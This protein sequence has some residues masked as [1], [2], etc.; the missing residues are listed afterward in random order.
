M[1]PGKR[2]PGEGRL[3]QSVYYAY[4]AMSAV[5]RLLPERVAYPAAQALGSLAAKRSKKRD[6]VARNLA[7][8]TGKP[9]DSPEVRSLVV[10]AFRSYARYWF[11][12]FALVREDRAFFLDRFCCPDLVKI[13][14]V[15]ARGKGAIVAVG[16]LGNWDAAGAWVGAN[17][18]LLV[19]VAEVLKPRRMYD[20]F[21]A[22][23]AAL[24]MRIYPA[25]AGVSRTLVEEV[26]GGAV[27]A[28]LADR[29][30]KGTG[31]EVTFF[32]EKTTFPPGTASIA[33]ETGIPILV[34]GVFGTVHEEGKRGWYAEI[35]DPIEVPEGAGK[36][37]IPELTQRVATE[38]ERLI[39][40][41]PQE[42]HVFQPFWTAD[43]KA[44]R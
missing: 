1:P 3:I 44:P 24:G 26:N 15:L 2:P 6:Q 4:V 13:E 11:E 41:H 17:G 29:D 33:I 8:I 37:A 28:I 39:A 22:H 21:V 5:L 7:R 18:H 14:Q 25:R 12:T 38:L 40:M 16:H 9:V 31:V 30:L 10:E 23:R 36:E 42:W 19:T 32:G 27:L 34:A 20:F 43:R 35:S